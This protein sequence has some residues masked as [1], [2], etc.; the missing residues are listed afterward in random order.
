[1][2]KSKD[3]KEGAQMEIIQKM[4]DDLIPYD[5]NPRKNDE[6]VEKVAESIREFGFKV[7]VI[8]DKDNI[9]IAGH[10]RVRAAKELG[11]DTIPVIIADDLTEEQVRAFRLADNKVS[12]FSA[13][14]F[15]KL[16]EELLNISDIDMTEFGFEEIDKVNLDDFFSDEERTGEKK[17]KRV[18]CPHCGEEF[19][20]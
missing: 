4:I 11:L 19:E 8:I 2:L 3:R 15:S 1:M 18:T 16:E 7:P 6:A 12:E 13:W 17:K 9:I 14:D 10:T 5:N 20:I